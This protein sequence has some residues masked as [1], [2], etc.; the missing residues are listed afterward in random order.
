MF[1]DNDDC[2]TCTKIVYGDPESNNQTIVKIERESKSG[3]PVYIKVINSPVKKISEIYCAGSKRSK[4]NRGCYQNI[5]VERNIK[6]GQTFLKEM[7]KA[8]MKIKNKPMLRSSDTMQNKIIKYHYDK[9]KD[10]EK[11]KKDFVKWNFLD[12]DL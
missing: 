4:G 6:K 2:K 3:N 11:T 8:G 1:V 9:M 7:S 12:A 10:Y 5:D